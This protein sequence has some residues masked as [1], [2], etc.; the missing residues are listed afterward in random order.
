MLCHNPQSIHIN[1]TIQ[2]RCD[3][4]TLLD[5][6]NYAKPRHKGFKVRDANGGFTL[7]KN[8][9]GTMLLQLITV[10]AHLQRFRELATLKT[11]H[12]PRQLLFLG[13]H[14]EKAWLL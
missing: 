3:P 12:H 11:F 8:T 9:E 14:K 1:K 13:S 4:N 7:P 2:C 5:F 10:I 6:A